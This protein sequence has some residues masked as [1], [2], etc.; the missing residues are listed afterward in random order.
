MTRDGVVFWFC[1]ACLAGYVLLVP[2]AAHAGDRKWT[3]F[4]QTYGGKVEFS[5]GLS[6][7]ECEFARARSLGLPATKKEFAEWEAA[8]PTSASKDGIS[9]SGGTTGAFRSIGDSDIKQAECL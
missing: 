2:P 9:F 7:K 6:R 3:L 8:H 4:S 1:M 5:R